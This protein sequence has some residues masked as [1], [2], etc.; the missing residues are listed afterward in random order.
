[1]NKNVSEERMQILEMVE[2]GKITAEE[3]MELLSALEKSDDEIIPK[4]GAKWLKVRVRT[5]DDKPKVNINIPISLVD[6]GLKLAKTYDPKLK[7][8][9]LDQ[10]N[11]E[12]IIDAVKNGAEGKIV[13]VEDEENKT[14]IKVYVE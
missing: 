1:M 10:I 5:M 6:V 7:E 9:G 4:S 3:G 14:K 12:E 11:I 8:S 2:E 13:D